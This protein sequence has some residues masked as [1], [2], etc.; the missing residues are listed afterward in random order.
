MALKYSIFDKVNNYEQHQTCFRKN[1][2]LLKRPNPKIIHK[3]S[4]TCLGVVHT[5]IL[6]YKDVS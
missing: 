3:F 4:D 6:H 5:R 2:L 1:Y